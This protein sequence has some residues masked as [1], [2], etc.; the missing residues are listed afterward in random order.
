MR[1]LRGWDV[2]VGSSG[3]YRR[4]FF[5]YRRAL[6]MAQPGWVRLALPIDSTF[7]MFKVEL[8]LLERNPDDEGLASAR[9]L[10][11][12]QECASN[13][14]KEL[15]C[16]LIATDGLLAYSPKADQLS[17]FAPVRRIRVDF[18]VSWNNCFAVCSRASSL[19]PPLSPLSTTLL[20]F[21]WILLSKEP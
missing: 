18:R 13:T 19:R 12:M 14:T 8:G 20:I 7:C 17:I 15:L 2:G 21:D 16:H 4:Q 3:R 9:Y 11:D 10:E 5:P 6:L 1:W